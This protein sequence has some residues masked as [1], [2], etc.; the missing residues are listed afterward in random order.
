[1]H[2]TPSIVI[3]TRQT[4]L[5]GL[6]ARW[7]TDAQAK[8]LLRQSKALEVER[9]QQ[10]IR[11]R[12]AAGTAVIDPDVAAAAD[13]DEYVA[14]DRTYHGMLQHLK[15][16]L[17]L[18]LPIKVIDRSYL[19]NF[20]FDSAAAIVVVGQDGLVANTAK[21]ALGLPIVGVNPDPER[22]DGILLPFQV[23]QT[24]NA[25]KRVLD[26]KFRARQVTLAEVVLNDGQKMLAFN[27][28]FIGCASHVSARYTLEVDGRSEAQSSSGVIISTG[29][30]STGWLSSVF[31]MA[32]GVAQMMSAPG[33]ESLRLDWEDRRLAWVVREPFASRHSQAGLVAGLLPEQHEVVIESLMPENGVVFSDGIESDFLPFASGTIARFRASEQRAQLVTG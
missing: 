27:D 26:R 32:R 8:F 21:Y 4:R 10:S 13:F 22:I 33:V 19:P 17:E 23:A 18:G 2:F 20:D 16:D 5:Q 6:R 9:R 1:M 7:V 3:V 12:G 15:H 11:K 30:G 14:E 28:F 25:V 24:R 31:N 29:A